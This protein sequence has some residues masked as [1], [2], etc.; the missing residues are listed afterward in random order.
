MSPSSDIAGRG[1]GTRRR[2]LWRSLLGTVVLS[3]LCAGLAWAGPGS[4][5]RSFN[6]T[7][8]VITDFGD[9][10]GAQGFAMAIG[11]EGRIVVAGSIGGGQ[12]VALARY[13]PN[14]RLD[15]SFADG[16]TLVPDLGTVSGT[17]NAVAIDHRGRIVIAGAA[18]RTS[19][20][21]AGFMIAR[22]HPNGTPDRS[23][24]GD[25][26]QLTQIGHLAEVRAIA[27]DAHNRIIA[28]GYSAATRGYGNLKF[29]VARYLPS[30]RLDASFGHNG[31]FRGHFGKLPGGA[32]AGVALDR[33][34]RIVLGGTAVERKV[35]AYGRY[36]R[37]AVVRLTSDGHL[38]RSFGQ[39][40]EARTAFGKNSATISAI[41]ID[42][43][44]F[45]SDGKVIDRISLA[46]DSL[47]IDHEGR[48][49][50]GGNVGGNLPI[51]WA[52]ARVRP[53]GAPDTSFGY[54]RRRNGNAIQTPQFSSAMALCIDR[55]DRIV[56]AGA[57]Q[58]RYGGD[59]HTISF[60]LERYH[61]N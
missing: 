22:F 57:T 5:D 53:S 58:G 10:N 34:G 35:G 18:R 20:G 41:A 6:G 30:G 50:L 36:T 3:V 60:A 59:S 51:A 43:R 37:F 25:G 52:I 17:A 4:P 56:G 49:V 55:Q 13:L 27:I 26:L 48:I 45:S 12:S 38:D 21:D 1:A 16:G 33:H 54:P 40:G 7:G 47:A 8:K 28:A 46:V 32:A 23:F 15:P 29:T 11:P 24:S 31:I 2:R 61:S 9:P 39:D 19:G 14:G 44:S 42:P